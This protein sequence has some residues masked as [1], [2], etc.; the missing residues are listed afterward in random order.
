VELNLTGR[1]ALVTG[2][3][4]GLGF[5]CAKE[6]SREGARVVICARDAERL[7]AAARQISQETGGEVAA[8]AAD[9]TKKRDLATLLAE[10]KAA[11]NHIDILV[12]STGHPA[13]SSFSQAGD[14]QWQRGIDLMLQPVIELAR[15]LLPDMRRRRY[16]R[17][18]F[19]G[20][21]YGL[22]PEPTSVVQS[23]LRSG[24]NALSKCIAAE[25]A[26]DGVTANVICPGYFDTPLVADLAQKR[27]AEAGCSPQKVLEKWRERAPSKTFGRPD[28][29]G[30]LVA[31]LASPRGEFV[32]GTSITMD[33]GAIRQY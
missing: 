5:A 31:F 6:L 18:L 2:A 21:I 24:L 12:V 3:S 30:A 14:D 22:E 33:G 1:A 23:T 29:L 27:A 9:L 32:N 11:L 26:E 16:G 7:A 20:S 19:I 15:G 13:K 28:D 25:V 8:V 17:L 4:H 10:A